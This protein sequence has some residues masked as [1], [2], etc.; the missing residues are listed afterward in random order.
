[1]AGGLLL[2][3]LLM[4][5]NTNFYFV[6]SMPNFDSVL[7]L[8]N[9]FTE[10]DWF[11]YKERKKLGGIAGGYTD[12]IPLIYGTREELKAQ[13]QHPALS[14]F[15]GTVKTI[16][17]IYSSRNSE[18][19]PARAFLVR[20]SANSEIKRHKDKGTIS[21]KTHRIH[22]PIITN[23]LCLFTIGDETKHLAAGEIWLIDNTDKY[24]SVVNGGDEFRIHLIVDVLDN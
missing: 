21:A 2:Y 23:S 4:K 5:E 18:V 19:L 8:V 10:N 14:S 20:M 22:L 15:S 13:R 1:M 16:C 9:N 7:A 3:H 6:G 24:H 17:S 12:T 11:S